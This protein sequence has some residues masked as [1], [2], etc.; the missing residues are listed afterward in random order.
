MKQLL[1]IL[2]IIIFSFSCHAK[3]KIEF[4]HI[5]N[6][7]TKTDSLRNPYNFYYLCDLPLTKVGELILNDS[8]QP[9]DNFVTSKLMDTISGCKMNQ[10]GFFLKVFEKILDK[11]DG[12]LSEVVGSYTWNFINKRPT[13]FIKHIDTLNCK[14]IK[15]WVD[16]TFYEMYFHYSTQKLK[17]KCQELVDK[18]KNIKAT[19]SV[20]CFEKE[21]AYM[22]KNGP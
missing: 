21:M 8:I 11:A 1:F 4:H 10:L 16:Y 19:K 7:K 15:K 22:I 18:L 6:Q 9:S 17:I 3:E 20:A 2:T 13:E 14:Q 12:A 5:L